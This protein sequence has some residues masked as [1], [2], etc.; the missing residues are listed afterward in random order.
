MV[1]VLTHLNLQHVAGS[2]DTKY[3]VIMVPS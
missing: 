2:V 1:N 3:Q